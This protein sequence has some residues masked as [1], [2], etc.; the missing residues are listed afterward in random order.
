[1][2]SG[3]RLLARPRPGF[4]GV[5]PVRL[6]LLDV[7]CEE[8]PQEGALA[9]HVAAG[10]LADCLIDIGRNL[11]GEH[12]HERILIKNLGRIKQEYLKY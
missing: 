6:Y 5:D 2:G 4:R 11:E 8:Q 1:M 12:W 10:G 3:G 9:D 7:F